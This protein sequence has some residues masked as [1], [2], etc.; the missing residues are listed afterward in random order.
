MRSAQLPPHLALCNA[1][2]RHWIVFSANTCDSYQWLCKSLRHTEEGNSSPSALSPSP[3]CA[4]F[5][6]DHLLPADWSAL[7][8][9]CR[10]LTSPSG[11]FTFSSPGDVVTVASSGVAGATTAVPRGQ[12]A[13]VLNTSFMHIVERTCGDFV[14][15]NMIYHRLQQRYVVSPGVSAADVNENEASFT[16]W[17][18]K[19]QEER[20]NCD[21]AAEGGT[22]IDGEESGSD[23]G[24]G[25]E[26]EKEEAEEEDPLAHDALALSATVQNQR[27]CGVASANDTDADTQEGAEGACTPFIF[28]PHR[29]VVADCIPHHSRHFVV[30]VNHKPIVPGHLMVVP[31]RCVATMSA[32][33]REEVEDWGRVVH[34]T[35]RVLRRSASSTSGCASGCTVSDPHGMEGSFSIAI[36]QGVFAGQ[37]VPHLHTH[38][39]P[40]DPRGKLA[41][42]PED[43][44]LQQRRMPRTGLQMREETEMLR[45]LFACLAVKGGHATE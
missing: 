42:E 37:T 1:P 38:V 12:P 40:F 17:M 39:I 45:S 34:L 21:I 44:E 30:M 19:L 41:G 9:Q 5:R 25:G 22:R 23:S 13:E 20:D 32:L 16:A 28:F 2:C 33:T 15:N 31:I 18:Q 36:Q 35:I 10:R 6:L 4:R 43:E 24:S 7:L 27:V 11:S 14:P 3:V 26:K 29:I 8:R